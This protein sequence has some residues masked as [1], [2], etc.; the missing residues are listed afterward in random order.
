MACVRL[1]K[2]TTNIFGGVG[3]FIAETYGG[4]LQVPYSVYVLL[5]EDGSFYTGYTRHLKRRVGQHMNGRGARYT[6]I[7]KPKALVYH[8]EFKSRA[9]AMK[10]E[11]GIKRLKHKEKIRL[12]KSRKE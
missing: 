2:D 4:C 6:R 11:R 9:E 1:G 7:H 5:C 8:E 10:R 12:I 3:K